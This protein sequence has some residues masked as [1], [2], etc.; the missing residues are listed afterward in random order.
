MN[1]IFMNFENSKTS[2]PYLLILKLTDKLDL[3]RGG[4]SIALGNLSIYYTW[5]NIKSSYNYNKFKVSAPTWND[6]FELTND[7]YSVVDIQDYF[8][9]IL[10]KHGEIMDNP[11][12]KIYVNK[13][14]NRITFKIKT[15][16]YL[17]LLIPETMKMLGSTKNRITKDKYCE[18]VSCLF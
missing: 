5:K 7:S 12:V 10:K 14:E 1:T 18:N 3:R 11:S 13:M 16:Y 9:Y 17:E 8:E 2:E 6:K 4:K 15:E